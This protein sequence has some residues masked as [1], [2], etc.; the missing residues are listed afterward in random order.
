MID[1]DDLPHVLQVGTVF[2]TPFEEGCVVTRPINH[3]GGFI[4][5]D[6][7]GV[8]CQFHPDMVIAVGEGSARR[9]VAS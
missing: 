6:S 8:S 9:M 1:R 4:A 2:E 3:L 7:Q 5:L